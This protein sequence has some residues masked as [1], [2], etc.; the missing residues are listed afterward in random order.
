MQLTG[1]PSFAPGAAVTPSDT[2]LINCRA[3][4]V[5]G[6]GNVAVAASGSAAAVTL[7]AVPAGTLIPI[8]LD[9]GRVMATNT[10]ATLII[11]LQ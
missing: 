8:A 1:S 6:L 7:N 3:L 4:W 9:Q 5:G 10:T 2:T 11:A